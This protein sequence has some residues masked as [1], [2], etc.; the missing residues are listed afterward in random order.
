MY[1]FWLSFNYRLVVTHFLSFKSF[2]HPN[3]PL[4]SSHLYHSLSLIFSSTF[5]CT[6]CVYVSPFPIYYS[7]HCLIPPHH[8]FPSFHTYSSYPF[9]FPLISSSWPPFSL[10]LYVKSLLTPSLF[11]LPAQ[12]LQ[13]SSLAPSIYLFSLLSFL[14]LIFITVLLLN[15]IFPQ[16]YS[17]RHFFFMCIKVWDPVYFMSGICRMII[18]HVS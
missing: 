5:P 3:I 4:S 8:L 15:A 6:L 13:L 9:L 7:Q 2:N 14:H 17:H 10:S 18:L 12:L 16:S 1:L 11:L